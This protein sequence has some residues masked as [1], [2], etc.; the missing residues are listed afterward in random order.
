MEGLKKQKKAPILRENYEFLALN[1]HFFTKQFRFERS[2][3]SNPRKRS[4]PPPKAPTF[5]F[6]FEKI[7]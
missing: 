2:K 7:I 5:E 1:H 3:C 4:P 6:Q